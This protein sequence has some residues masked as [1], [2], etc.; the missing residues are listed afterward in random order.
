MGSEMCIRDSSGSGKKADWK[1][2]ARVAATTQMILAG[3]LDSDNLVSAIR[4]VNP[5]G[6]DVSSG[7]EISRGIKDPEKIREFVARA[8]ATE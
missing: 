3:G 1:V 6:V 7:V 2:A 4:T 8:R 5:W